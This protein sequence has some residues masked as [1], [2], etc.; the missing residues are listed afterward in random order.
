MCKEFIYFCLNEA[1]S[2]E[3]KKMIYSTNYF[4]NKINNL[5][6]EYFISSNKKKTE[7]DSHIL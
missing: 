4:L 3:R 1:S 6:V 7:V 5:H 2:H